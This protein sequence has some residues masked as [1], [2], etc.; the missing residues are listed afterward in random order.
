MKMAQVSCVLL[1]PL[2]GCLLKV[3]AVEP[4]PAEP[5]TA[6][7]KLTHLDPAFRNNMSGACYNPKTGMFWVCCNGGPS[8]FYGLVKAKN[9]SLVIATKGGKRAKYNLGKGDLEGICQVDYRTNLLYL[10]V[11]RVDKIREY[12]VSNYGNAKLKNEWD[13]SAFVPTKGGAGSEGITFVP[14][15]WLKKWGFTDADGNPYASKNGMGGLMFVAHQNG[16]RIYVFDLSPRKKTVHFVGAYK[17]SRAESSGLE[18]DRSSGLLY[19]WH[20]TGPN[21]LEVTKLSSYLDGDERRLSSI[22]EFLGPK[23][24]NLEGIALSPSAAKD[25]QCLIVDD[26]NQDGAA[27][28]FFRKFDPVKTLRKHLAE[29]EDSP[30][31]K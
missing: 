12:D 7:E 10:M 5:W 19:V 8:A 24:G 6:A 28:M 17:T 26:D 20:N 30:D 15:E 1:F 27:L 22:A 23:K 25:G 18:F 21:Y 9:G 29:Q 2:L 31:K 14:D 13:I 4:W 16:G 3:G 11:E